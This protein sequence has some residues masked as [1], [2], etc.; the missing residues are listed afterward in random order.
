MRSNTKGKYWYSLGN[1]E[2]ARPT[3]AKLTLSHMCIIVYGYLESSVLALNVRSTKVFAGDQGSGRP[4]GYSNQGKS[5]YRTR[6]G[7]R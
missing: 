3:P 1:E 6:E 7:R 2:M 4:V 5:E